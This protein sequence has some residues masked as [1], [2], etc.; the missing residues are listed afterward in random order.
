MDASSK[1]ETWA[2]LAGN[3][4]RASMPH[5]KILGLQ[6]VARLLASRVCTIWLALT[7]WPTLTSW[8]AA[9]FAGMLNGPWGCDE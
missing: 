5:G 3:M 7:S 8:L 2:K 4:K 1:P 6:M 9:G